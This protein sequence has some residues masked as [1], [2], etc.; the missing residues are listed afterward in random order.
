MDGDAREVLIGEQF[1]EGLASGDGSEEDDDLIEFQH[2]EQLQKLLRLLAFFQLDVVLLETVES[3]LRFV[4]DIDFHRLKRIK[5]G[6]NTT[7]STGSIGR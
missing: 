6:Y 7:S 1:V 3:Q 5:F 4:V 2:I